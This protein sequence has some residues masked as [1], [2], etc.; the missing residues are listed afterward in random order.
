MIV[1]DKYGEKCYIL[2]IGKKLYVEMVNKHA[3]DV[4]CVRPRG[5]LLSKGVRPMW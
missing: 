1:I 3:A 5:R 4:L 2:S